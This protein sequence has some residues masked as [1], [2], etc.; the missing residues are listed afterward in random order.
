M[1]SRARVRGHAIHPMLVVFPL[2]LLATA[3]AFDIVYLITDRH[4]YEVAAAYTIGAGII[5]GVIAALAGIIDWSGV[6]SG[7]TAKR[8][9]TLHGLGNVVVLVLFAASWLLRRAAVDWHATPG[10]LACSFA[11]I[12]LAIA[13]GWAGGELVERWGISVHDNANVDAPSSG[14]QEARRREPGRQAQQRPPSRRGA[15][16]A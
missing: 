15:A 9:A 13:T 1:L 5:G 11:G 7:T 4:G 8:V 16:R 12:A 6:P 14:S 3:V 10:A 2:G